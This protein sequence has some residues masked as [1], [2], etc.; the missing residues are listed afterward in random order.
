MKK[1]IGCGKRL[2]TEF[3]NQQGY[4]KKLENDYCLRCFR[5]R[6]YNDLVEQDI[7]PKAFIDNIKEV[8]KT[9]PGATFYYILDIFDLDGS[10]LKELEELIA[11]RNVVIVINKIDLLPKSVKLAK[12][13]RY[14]NETFKDSKLNDKKVIMVSA[15]GQDSINE[16]LDLLVKNV[17]KQ[18]FVGVSNVGKSSLINALMYATDLVPTI[19]DSKYFNTTLDLIEIKLFPTVVIVDTPGVARTSSIAHLMEK[20]DWKYS[21]FQKEVKQFTFQLNSDQTIFFAGLAWFSYENNAGYRQ[22]FHIYT[23]KEIEL[24]RTKT[25]NANDYWTRNKEVIKPAIKETTHQ[26]K[27]FTFNN[28]DIG[29]EYDIMIS[30]LGWVNLIIEV[31]CKLVFTIPANEQ[32]VLIYKRKALI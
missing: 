18:Y 25:I 29:Q 17:G 15:F 9:D 5:I 31:P 10:R 11:H 20:D 8:I 14:I 28:S 13:R 24:H 30:G 16:F 7:D 2:Q 12:I 4:A 3:E 26:V 1:C 19:V 6:H 32:E 23:N 21:Y 27:E 22:N